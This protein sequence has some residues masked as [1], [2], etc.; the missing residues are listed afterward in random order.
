VLE[1][2]Q[3]CVGDIDFNQEILTKISPKFYLS[4]NLYP[5]VSGKT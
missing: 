4:K 2:I 5:L 3:G 1:N